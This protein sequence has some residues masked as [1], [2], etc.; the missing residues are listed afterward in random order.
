MGR[1]YVNRKAGR[2]LHA[3][4]PSRDDGNAC[5]QYKPQLT[6]YQSALDLMWE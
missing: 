5:L 4:G 1:D 2:S 6:A 3:Y